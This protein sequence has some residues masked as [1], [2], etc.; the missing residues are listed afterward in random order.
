VKSSAG[1]P[2]GET[3]CLETWIKD[4]PVQTDA[5]LGARQGPPSFLLHEIAPNVS[6]LDDF[7]RAPCLVLI[8]VASASREDC[9][10]FKALAPGAQIARSV[11]DS[12]A[13]DSEDQAQPPR[14]AARQ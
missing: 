2:L 7:R 8:G 10:C 12:C 3:H 9:Q 13:E 4:E 14:D 11:S 5:M 1:V 6:D